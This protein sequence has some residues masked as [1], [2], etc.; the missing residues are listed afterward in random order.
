MRVLA[1]WGLITLIAACWASGDA[2]AGWSVGV[3]VGGPCYRPYYRPYWGGIGIG[4]NF[5][6]G[7]YPYYPVYAVAPAPVVVAPAP[8]VVGSAPAVQ[9]GYSAQSPQSAPPAAPE[10]LAPPV[11]TSSAA[12][13]AV[14]T[15]AAASP[16]ANWKAE[17]DTCLQQLRSTQE[18]TRA[19]AL[20]QLGRLKA[21]RATG[22]MI[23]ALNEDPSPV[24]REA[25]ARGLGLIA[26]PSTLAALQRA[27]LDDNDREVRHSAS[28]AADVIRGN[29]RR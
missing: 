13:P 25:A 9:P 11:P 26:A 4:F 29:L 2:Q 18:Q 28:F 14:T 15:A 27:A 8:V 17:I 21:T 12:Q 20:V 6:P 10:P 5:Y 19:E 22:P 1:R 24:V 23:K 7:Y 3:R 16:G